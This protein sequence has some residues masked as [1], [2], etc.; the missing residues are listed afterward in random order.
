[1]TLAKKTVNQKKRD[2]GDADE[3]NRELDSDNEMM[4]A[5][6]SPRIK[7]NCQHFISVVI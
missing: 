2:Y 1:L 4:Y 3:I 5:P 6:L 7:K